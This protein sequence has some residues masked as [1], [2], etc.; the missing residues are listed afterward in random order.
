[1]VFCLCNASGENI[2]H[3]RR[4]LIPGEHLQ[5]GKTYIGCATRTSKITKKVEQ[6]QVKYLKCQDD[7]NDQLIIPY[8]LIGK[9][10]EVS[11][12]PSEDAEGKFVERVSSFIADEEDFPVVVRHVFGDLP[13]LPF[14]FTGL[15]SLQKTLTEQTVMAT[16]L[17]ERYHIP[18]EIAFPSA[19]KFQLALNDRELQESQ[20]LAEASNFCLSNSDRY[21]KNMKVAFTLMPNFAVSGGIKRMPPADDVRNAD[22]VMIGI[23]AATEYKEPGIADI[24]DKEQ[25]LRIASTSDIDSD[26][27]EDDIEELADEETDLSEIDANSEFHFGWNPKTAQM[28]LLS[29]DLLPEQQEYQL[30]NETEELEMTILIDAEKNSEDTS[31]GV[32]V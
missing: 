20:T 21:V 22:G 17:M 2:Q 10:Y 7:K 6:K 16:T 9:F 19:V 15:L 11:L 14:C 23:G 12:T 27:V 29:K 28:L 30:E 24:G 32:E 18:L 4:Q 13:S 25:R 3:V 26:N 5:V 31:S 8:A 1:M